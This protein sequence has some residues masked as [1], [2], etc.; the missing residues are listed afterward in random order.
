MPRRKTNKMFNA[1]APLPE[2][3]SLSAPLTLEAA[4]GDGKTLRKLKILA[5]AG[6]VID[7]MGWGP[8]LVDLAGME[9]PASAPILVDHENS[10]NGIAGAGT[11]SVSSGKLSIDGVVAAGETGAKIVALLE[12]GIPLQASIGAKPGA[13]RYVRPGEKIVANGR[14]HKAPVNGMTFVESCALRE[15]SIVAVGG[16]GATKVQLAAKAAEVGQMNFDDWLKANGFEADELNEKK[17]AALRAAYESEQHPKTPPAQAAPRQEPEPAADDPVAKN[18]LN[19]KA[20]AAR[21]EAIDGVLG[22]KAP[23]LRLRAIG[24]GWDA[25]RTKAELELV[26]LRAS[27]P[28]GPSPAPWQNAATPEIIE[29]SLCLT[30]G[31]KPD[32]VALGVEASKREQVMNEAVSGRMRGF[33]LH[34]LYDIVLRAAGVTFVGNRKSDEFIRATFDANRTLCASGGFSTLSLTGILSNVA[35][36]A[37]ID[38]Y[39]QVQVTWPKF[40]AVRQHTD[41][42][43]NTR[44]RLDSS[45]AF[46][47]VAQDGELKHVGL[48]DD[49]YTNQ[50]DTYGAIIALT[51]QMQINDDLGAFMQIPTI[52]GN[53]AAIRTEEAVFVLLLSNPSSFFHANNRNLA[54]GAGSALGISSISTAEQKF[55]DQI[56]PNKKPILISPVGILVPST[57]KVAAETIY[58]ERMLI[59]GTA[60]EAQPAANPHAGKYPVVAS[61]YLNNT[62]IKDQDGATI[63]GQSSTAWYLFADPAIRAAIAVAFLN[64]QQTPTIQSAETDFS[65]LGMQWRA[66]HDFGVGMEDPVAMVKSNGA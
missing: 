15:I 39:Q 54:T 14:T 49:T 23:E 60:T 19:A 63:T 64:G 9:V 4:E 18:R 45:G 56:D 40:C 61:P 10:I 53:M 8:T 13:T 52:L 29:A 57:L 32:R 44:Y 55:L 35:N 7:P 34:A 30:S 48:T 6:G 42:K 47:K 12:S 2:L 21:I 50:L 20:E 38:A 1:S 65:T 51:R 59:A 22:D 16:D 28:K 27:A 24:E 11:P 17:T 37:L 43:S 25:N 5:Y 33:G 46:T 3:L 62:A 36:K 58:S 41:F 26:T 31:M 66:V